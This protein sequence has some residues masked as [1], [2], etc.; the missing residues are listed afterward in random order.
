VNSAT[1]RGTYTT[2]MP[3]SIRRT[4]QQGARSITCNTV[5]EMPRTSPH[6]VPAG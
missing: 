3:R 4:E 6:D 1:S 5:Y 2:G